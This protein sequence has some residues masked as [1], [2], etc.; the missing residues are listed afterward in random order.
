MSLLYSQFVLFVFRQM[1]SSGVVDMT[2]DDVDG[3]R[4][5]LCDPDCYIINSLP[6]HSASKPWPLGTED[7]V[8][9][10]PRCHA[11]VAAR[12]VYY[13]VVRPSFNHVERSSA[14][15]SQIYAATSRQNPRSTA[16]IVQPYC[17]LQDTGNG[18]TAA[19]RFRPDDLTSTPG[20]ILSPSTSTSR[21]YTGLATQNAVQECARTKSTYRKYLSKSCPN[22]HLVAS[23]PR[24]RTVM[25]TFGQCRPVVQYDCCSVDD[26]KM[27]SCE[28]SICLGRLDAAAAAGY[29][30]HDE[31]TRL[32]SLGTYQSTYGTL[33]NA[34]SS[35]NGSARMRAFLSS[36]RSGKQPSVVCE[37]TRLNSAV[38]TTRHHKVIN[39]FFT[40]QNTYNAFFTVQSITLTEAKNLLNSSAL[41]VI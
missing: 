28:N 8:T 3:S 36:D 34:A 12:P 22:I 29:G 38:I 19:A 30:V 11:A 35:R 27:F 16:A 21:M 23:R 10:S 18:V 37:T 24:C 26:E 15:N 20:P 9:S 1:K 33:E 6:A 41:S 39:T 31:R 14:P 32:T 17:H 40:D 7:Q 2:S 25:S 5:V 4:C 13:D